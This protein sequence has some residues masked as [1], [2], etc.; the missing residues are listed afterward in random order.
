MI[1]LGLLPP[2]RLG[3]A[4]D[5]GWMTAFAQHADEVGFE[6]LLTVEHVVVPV[7]YESRYP[8]SE[9]GRMPLPED[10]E[11]PDPLDLLAFLAARTERIR[12]GTGILVLPEHH[13]LHLAKRCATIDR[14]SDG[15]LFLGVGVG[16]LREEMAALGI[17]PETRGSRT[18]E[19]I[20]AL[21]VIWREDTPSF[22]GHHY[23]FDAVRSHPKPVQPS[24]PIL[25]GGH[26]PA[27]ARRAG[28]LGDGFFPLGLSG[29]LLTER[30]AQVQ[31]AATEAGRDPGT[32]SL[33]LGGLLGDDDAITAAIDR[34]AERVVLS[35]RTADLDELRHAMDTASALVH[36]VG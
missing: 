26:S 14:L 32:V 22:A 36:R 33:T 19:G 34:D 21:R 25:V 30:W 12:L 18:D 4:S 24:I 11:L 13:P 3:V 23:A 8:Y 20:E 6:S 1:A 35:S 31:D 28:R 27:A 9:T 29:D 7:G 17:D 5:P 16:W 15:R 2:Y 10:C